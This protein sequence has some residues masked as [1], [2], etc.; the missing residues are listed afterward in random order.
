MG[1]FDKLF[2][3]LGKT[4]Q[5]IDLEELFQGYAP[6]SEEFY[7]NLEETLVLADAGIPT[8]ERVDYLMRRKTWE[9]R[10]RKG[11][12]A[13]E[14]LIKILTGLLDV[15]DTEL[16][17]GTKPSVILNSLASGPN[18]PARTLSA[19]RRGATRRRSSMTGSARRKRA[20]RMSS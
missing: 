10:Y 2:G 5:T 3:G 11:E 19:T 8:A 15:G 1:L 4:R 18:A 7:E 13:R 17:L 14:G 6:D 20:E 9:D 16:K 12:E